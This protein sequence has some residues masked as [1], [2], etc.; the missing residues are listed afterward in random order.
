MSRSLTL[1]GRTPPASPQEG[2]MN[3]IVKEG[4]SK[5]ALFGTLQ[6]IILIPHHYQ[7]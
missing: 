3:S 4:A 1:T 5:V 6:T 7:L 2:V